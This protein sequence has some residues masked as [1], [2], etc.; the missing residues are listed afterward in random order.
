MT[1]TLA[2]CG[3]AAIVAVW[4]TG[5]AA[6]TANAQ[7]FS[8]YNSGTYQSQPR[9]YGNPFG[10][11]SPVYTQPIYNPGFAPFAATTV[12]RYNPGTTLP[13]PPQ[14]VGWT[15]VP[16]V[17]MV[18]NY[19]SIYGGPMYTPM[20]MPTMVRFRYNPTPTLNPRMP[21]TPAGLAAAQQLS[22]SFFN[23]YISPFGN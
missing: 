14:V 13:T 10:P 23:P 21:V 5:I 20:V 11:Y 1:R 16:T 8:P 15:T 6:S 22:G 4:F 2:K 9:I 12:S 7:F 17:S 18:P 19:P 3:V